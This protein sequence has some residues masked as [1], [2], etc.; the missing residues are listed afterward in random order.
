MFTCQLFKQ[1]IQLLVRLMNCTRKLTLSDDLLNAIHFKN[2]KTRTVLHEDWQDF[3][4]TLSI[5][6]VIFFAINT[7]H[8]YLQDKN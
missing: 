1:N 4:F 5:F 6:S 7:D 3:L 8:I 2:F